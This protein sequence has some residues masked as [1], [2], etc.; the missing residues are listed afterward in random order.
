MDIIPTDHHGQ[1]TFSV[2]SIPPIDVSVIVPCKD[3]EGNIGILIDE[4]AVALEGQVFEIIVIDDGS[5]DGTGTLLTA[6]RQ[7]GRPW[8][9]Q[10][11][12]ENSC[13]QSAALRSGL[14]CANGEI[15]VTIDGDGQNDPIFIPTLI[16]TLQQGSKAVGLAAGQRVA[17]KAS[18]AKRYASS[19]ANWLRKAL[20]KD[21]TRDSGCGLKAIPRDVFLRLPYF[22]SWHRFMPALV[23][24]EGY[25]VMHV[26]VIDRE[27]HYGES[28]YG[29]FD[30]GLRGIPDLFGVWWLRR[31]RR[32]IPCVREIKES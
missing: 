4:I 19:F 29:I 15:I 20:L 21:G 5:S 14:L 11:H 27:R 28:K 12:H 26:D 6:Y 22:D 2:Y 24:R 7:D 32:S 10:L 25:E 13:G 17:R 3:E 30:R 9:R 16:E 31:R 8:L 1:Q 23:I 18:H